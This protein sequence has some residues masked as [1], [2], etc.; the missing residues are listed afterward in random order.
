MISRRNYFSITVIMLVILFLF[1]F[2]SAAVNMWGEPDVNVHV[3]EQALSSRDTAYQPGQKGVQ[4]AAERPKKQVAYVGDAEGPIQSVVYYY[5]LYTK[6]NMTSYACLEESGQAAQEA[7]SLPEMMVIDSLSVDWQDVQSIRLLKDYASAGCTLV[8]CGLPEPS[9]IEQNGRVR[10]LLGIQ[11]VESPGKMV[12]GIHLYEGFLLGGESLYLAADEQE[13]LKRQ[14]LQL[15]I[16]CYRLASGTKVYMKGIIREEERTPEDY[17]PVIW[18][19]AFKESGIFVINGS[20]MEETMGVGILSAISAQID[21]YTLYPVVNAQNLVV[22]NFPV[23][24][25]ENSGQM[26]E[27]YTRSMPDAFRDILWPGLIS[28]CRQSDMGLTFMLAPQLDYS[29][30]I[31]PDERWIEYYSTLMHEEHAEM[32]LS[33]SQVSAVPAEQKLKEDMAFIGAQIPRYRLTSLYQGEAEEEQLQALFGQL[34]T[35]WLHTVVTDYPLNGEVV[36]YLSETV[37]RQGMV[38]DGM[39]RTYLD[40]LR[41]RCVETA[42]GYNNIL[43]DLINA[44]YPKDANDSWERFSPDLS[45]NI[46]SYG[47]PFTG[48]QATTLSESDRLI[49]RFLALDYEESR[50]EADIH[51]RVKNVQEP[52][53]FILRTRGETVARVE[54]GSSKAIERFV[55]LIEARQP[56]V[57]ISLRRAW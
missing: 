32:G 38:A 6:R 31:L 39:T 34:D 30:D 53:W 33:L 10:E 25:E 17:P 26:M 24:A 3:Q 55:Y 50:Q 20:Y 2:S 48:F 18:R 22:A 47:K 44:A 56:E 29:D 11:S 43:I 8:F 7:G 13:H 37:T 27:F 35:S 4:E 54:G 28:A 1:Q 9:V 40:D 5:A 41:A 19:R 57:V 42:L 15:N 51:L 46:R 49:R 12:E 16:P 21:A 36:G 52:V 14:N 23:M 45:W